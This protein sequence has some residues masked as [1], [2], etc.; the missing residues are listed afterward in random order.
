MLGCCARQCPLMLLVILPKFRTLVRRGAP[1]AQPLDLEIFYRGAP[2][3][4]RIWGG[5]FKSET[6][7]LAAGQPTLD[8]PEHLSV[9]HIDG[10]ESWLEAQGV[11]TV[12]RHTI[13]AKAIIALRTVDA[14][15]PG[16]IDEKLRKRMRYT[17]ARPLGRSTPRDGYSGFVQPVQKFRA[18]LRREIPASGSRIYGPDKIL[19]IVMEDPSH[20]HLLAV[21]RTAHDKVRM[22][23]GVI[24]LTEKSAIERIKELDAERARLFEQAKEEALLKA[25]AA[26]TDL[27][28]LGLDYQLVNGAAKPAKSGTEKILGTAKDVPCPI[29]KFLTIPPHD[30][31]THR[32]QKKKAP[33]SA[34]KLNEKGL[35]KV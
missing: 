33:F 8:G 6:K 5:Y 3:T 24:R 1:K 22:T 2:L 19:C 29:C 23:R 28:A 16:T 31:R 17:S 21:W 32:N 9:E 26:I 14:S 13:L 7:A 15:R 34:A 10:F 35:V 11:T 25:T 18:L 30:R 12:H 27:I 20:R 4:D